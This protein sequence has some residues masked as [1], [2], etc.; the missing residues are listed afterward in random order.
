MTFTPTGT[1]PAPR[2][3]APVR[4]GPQEAVERLRDAATTE[5]GRLRIIGAALA[6]L[7]LLFGAVTAWQV[8]GRASAARDVAQRSEPLS[9]NAAE[10]YRSL[11]DADSTQAGGF[12]VDGQEPRKV[13][14]RYQDD[15][16]TASRLI[17][18]AASDSSGSA[19]ARGQVTLLNE[20]LPV[21]TGLV[22]TARTDNRQGLPLGGAYLR[23]A[24]QLMST[25]ILPAARTLYGIE[26]DQLTSDYADATA[27]PWGA[28]ALGLVTL[29]ALGWAQ[30]RTFLRTNRVFN[31]GL[32][33]ATAA[34]AVVLVWLVAG[35]TVSRVELDGSRDHQVASLR[36]LTQARIDSLQARG[37]EN[38]TLVAR[39]AGASYQD[40]YQHEMSALTGSADTAAGRPAATS[41]LGK[42][43]ALADDDAGRSPVRDAVTAAQ[44]WKVRHQQAHDRDTAGDYDTAVADV[45][46]GEDS[47][48][49]RVTATTGQS[50]DTVDRSLGLAIGHETGELQDSVSGAR[51]AL[52]GLPV[53]AVLLGLLGAAAAVLGIGRRLS[54]FR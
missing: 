27:L 43:E 47:S 32:V 8:T 3:G 37:D 52:T 44:Q 16:A 14:D 24:D 23:Y 13:T 29:A 51:G 28:W 40:S 53:G 48:G 41:L 26:S 54:E 5:P 35:H 11:A 39:G 18:T 7:V 20:K 33:G 12:L 1:P 10:I 25:T 31:H 42:A 45:I 17:A 19:G 4:S 38:L 46:G 36:T 9:A 34:A 21:Y 30:R 15:I 50:F 22:E 6:L 49:R 2:T